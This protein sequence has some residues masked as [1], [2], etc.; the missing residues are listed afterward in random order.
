[1]SFISERFKICT[2][3]CILE[4]FMYDLNQQFK[5]VPVGTSLV[6]DKSKTD[7]DGNTSTGEIEDIGRFHSL[8]R[9]H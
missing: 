4:N 2:L 5:T 8:V 7:K 9:F 6:E 1:M 3:H